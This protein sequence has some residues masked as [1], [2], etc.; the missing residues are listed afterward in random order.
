MHPSALPCRVIVA[1]LLLRAPLMAQSPADRAALDS[2]ASAIPTWDSVTDRR[3]FDD[4]VHRVER[5]LDRNTRGPHSWHV[6]GLTLHAMS[7]HGFRVKV[8][9]YHSAGTSYRR[10]AM[11]A[12]AKAIERAAAYAPAAEALAGIVVSMRARKLNTDFREPLERAGRQPDA[13]AVVHLALARLAWS[14]GN[15]DS[16]LVAVARYLERGG[17]T[18]IGAIEAARAL[19]ALERPADGVAAY[20]SG[21]SHIDS[22]GRDAY[23]EDLAWVAN[24][25][26]LARFDS[27]PIDSVAIWTHLFWRGRDALEMRQ[28]G[29]R[30]TEHLRRWVHAHQN[31]QVLRPNDAPIHAEGIRDENQWGVL[32]GRDPYLSIVLSEAALSGPGW[33]LFQRTQW[34]V[35]DRGA[36]YIRH[37][38]PTKRISSPTGPPNESWLY[39]RAIDRP[40][41]H[42]L[43]S[44]A[45]GTTAATTLVASLPLSP[46]MLTSR[47]ELDSRYQALGEYIGSRRDMIKAYAGSSSAASNSEFQRALKELRAG[48][49]PGSAVV[50]VALGNAAAGVTSGGPPGSG[51]NAMPTLSTSIPQMAKEAE[52]R[53]RTVIREGM[54]TDG[55]PLVFDRQLDAAIQLHGMGVAPGQQRRVLAVYSVDGASVAPRP[56]PDGNPGFFY[57]MSIRVVALDEAGGI[58]RQLD[59]VRNY[60]TRDSLRAGQHLTGYVELP[61]PPGVYRARVL[62]Q[63]AGIDAAIAGVR[64]GIDLRQP[65]GQPVMSDLILG[66]PEGALAWRYDGLTVP[67]NPLNAFPRGST[68]SLF[69]QLSGLVPGKTYVIRVVVRRSE[70]D[71]SGKPLLALTSQA[72]ADGP[73]HNVMQSIDLRELKPGPYQLVVRIAESSGAAVL[74]RWRALNILSE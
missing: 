54:K 23:R 9:P 74:E 66:R 18:A 56:R 11:D 33:K 51:S 62:L 26:E 1:S 52:L 63:S 13:A 36:I 44:H 60:V 71:G 47:G 40:V 55:F 22:A 42:F 68:A 65:P 31:F 19:A 15:Y 43:G 35:D 12:F 49:N 8:T 17:D 16:A 61:V 50:L 59:T 27:L 70:D 38:E 20:Q 34:E 29:E 73:E 3:P 67:L 46:E 7:R 41:F 48:R 10:A 32:E 6:L 30:L 5:L 37:G 58:V 64:N 2:I 28:P 57:P 24:P 53:G 4:A 69:Y 45:L 39:Q 72:T 25:E 21:Y 14:G